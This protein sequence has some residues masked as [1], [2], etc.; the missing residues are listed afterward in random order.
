MFDK[1]R[2]IAMIAVTTC[3]LMITVGL[4]NQRRVSAQTC[5]PAPVGLASWWSGDGNA[6]DSRSRSNGTLIGNTNFVPGQVGQAFN[7][8]GVDDSVQIPH[9]SNQN[10]Q[11]SFSVEAWV[12][13]RS[14]PNVAPRILVKEEGGGGFWGMETGDGVNSNLLHVN[15]N[16]AV[17]I[18]TGPN[19]V[20][21]NQWSHVAFTYNGATGEIKLFVNGGVLNST[22]V[23][24][25]TTNNTGSLRIGNEATNVRDFDGLID[26]AQIYSR[27]LSDSEIL[28]TFNAGT[29]GN[30]KPTATVAPSGAVG[31]WA[32]DGNT[33]DISG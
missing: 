20:P 23:S 7:L 25:Q 15:I 3:L 5:S 30:C 26:E 24:V 28:A 9:N 33:N 21:L 31:W 4:L 17:I 32:G 1:I 11:G 8:D 19:S 16:N 18:S 27:L 14:S 2:K 22:T 6:L 12:F 10:I 29:A 13:P